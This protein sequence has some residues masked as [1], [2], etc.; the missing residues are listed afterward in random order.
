MD[1]LLS[2]LFPFKLYPRSVSVM[3]L[4]LRLMFGVMLMWHGMNKI[5]NVATAADVFPNP[6]G[7]GH[8]LSFYLV[9]F[10]E[11]ICSAAVIMGAFYRLALIPIIV[12]MAVAFFVVHHGQPFE[13]KE[14]SLIYLVMFVI[15]Y[16]MGAGSYSLDNI[17][18]KRLNEVRLAKVDERSEFK[19]VNY[20]SSEE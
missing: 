9:V 14:L 18:A 1:G 8:K 2:F 19:P 11:V 17:I 7:L 12:A 16:C 5:A 13:A 3:L 20:S 6:L 10:A 15:L 4:V